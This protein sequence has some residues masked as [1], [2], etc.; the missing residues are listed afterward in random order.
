[1]PSEKS[2]A[3]ALAEVF[4][5][6]SLDAGAL[7]ERARRAIR[8]CPAWV[9][10]L[11]ERIA[12]QFA[13]RG[14]VPVQ[15]LEA[16]IRQDT[17][18]VRKSGS[19]SP[20]RIKLPGVRPAMCPVP[21]PPSAWPVPPITTQG[22]LADWLGVTSAELDWLA[23]AK[24][25]ERT[26]SYEPL[27]NYVY[28]WIKKRSGGRRLI[29]APKPRLKALQRKVLSGILEQIPAHA[30]VH[31]FRRGRSIRT[32]AAPHGGQR[33]VLRI[34]LEHFFASI[35]RARVFGLF[36][37]AGY[38]DGVARLLAALCTNVPPSRLWDAC[39]PLVGSPDDVMQRLYLR[40]HLPQ[41]APT[42]PVL[43]NLCA[44]R[45]DCRLAA[46][47]ARLNGQYTRYADDL[48]FSGGAEL[49]RR[50][51]RFAIHVT[52]IA[53]EEGFAVQTRKTRIM[54]QGVR[55]E[56]AG[57]VVNRWTNFRRCDYDALKATLVNCIRRGSESQNRGGLLDFRAHLVGR[58]AFVTQ[59]NPRRGRRLQELLAQIDW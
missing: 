31:G 6:G 18:F 34:D 10:R 8:R 21:G 24:G 5:A 23:D 35:A 46:L 58:V 14:R 12:A 42:S 39:P 33:V 52:A 44:Y 9:V 45:L 32:Y 47:A 59:L 4:A 7:A 3:R 48:A 43:A 16:Y 17:A 13:T 55:Q 40:P 2:L 56:L 50:A 37:T 27:C 57:V 30:A 38:P 53:L 22:G 36:H 28:R 29:E 49:A 15:R 25:L 19:L 1:M 20:G 51:Q 41:G 11:S 26:A 54:R